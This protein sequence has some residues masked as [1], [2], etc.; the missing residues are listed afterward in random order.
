MPWPMTNSSN[1]LKIDYA[2][3]DFVGLWNRDDVQDPHCVCSRTGYIIN[4]ADCPVLWKS[5][6]QTEIALSTM[7]AEYVNFSTSC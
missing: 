2:D 7:E 1:E 6:L 5:G 3:A 4:F